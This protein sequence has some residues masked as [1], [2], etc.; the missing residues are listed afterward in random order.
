MKKSIIIIGGGASGM[1][2]AIELARKNPDI[3]VTILEK[4]ERIGKKILKT[5]NGRCNISSLNLKAEYYNEFSFMKRALSLVPG[6]EVLDFFRGIGLLTRQDEG[7]DRLYPYSNTATTV[8]EVLRRQLSKLGICV[9]TETEAVGIKKTD[10]FEIITNRQTYYADAVVFATGSMA[11][12]TTEGYRLIQSL[13]HRVTTLRPGLVP[14]KVQENLKSIQGIRVRCLASVYVSGQ[15][16]H[17]EEGEILFK[18]RGLSGVLALNLSR[19][20][21]DHSFVSLDLFPDLD[22]ETYLQEI[23]KYES[24]EEALM[25]LLPKMLVSEILRRAQDQSIA[26]IVSLLHHLSFTVTGDYGFEQAQITLGGVDIR[27]INE[28]FSS[29]ICPGLYIIGEV[30][31]IDGACGGYNLHFAW[32]SGIASARSLARF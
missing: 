14:L 27:D 2:C 11:Q 10:R 26:N 32:L 13:G 8:L 16:K 25:G 23:L 20:A 12:E 21:S 6:S 28:D 29:I 19:Y 15:K 31:N 1:T 24:M 4:N 17:S 22:I 3:A 30:L 5:G 7:S 9:E 18:D